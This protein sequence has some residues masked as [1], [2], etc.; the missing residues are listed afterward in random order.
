MFFEQFAFQ[1]HPLS[2][3]NNKLAFIFL[4]KE[5]RG[6]RGYITIFSKQKEKCNIFL[7]YILK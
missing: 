3:L 7:T 2:L 6:K 5:K 4:L 1:L